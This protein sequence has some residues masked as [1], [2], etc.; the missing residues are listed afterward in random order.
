MSTVGHSLKDGSKGS[1]SYALHTFRNHGAPGRH[2]VCRESRATMT[3]VQELNDRAVVRFSRSEYRAPTCFGRGCLRCTRCAKLLTLKQRS[4]A[5]R[6]AAAELPR[7]R[8][9]LA[10]STTTVRPS[11]RASV[12]LSVCLSVRLPV[13]PSVRLSVCPS[14]RL[15]V[16]PSVRLSVSPSVRLSV[17]PSVCAH[18]HEERIY[19]RF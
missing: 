14:I 5:K 18:C 3:P 6:R 4:F 19:G 9:I 11:V 13:C 2:P 1:T 16:C 17:C 8:L 12:R 7:L 15:S 10:T